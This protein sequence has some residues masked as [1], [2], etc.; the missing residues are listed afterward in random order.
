MKKIYLA[1]MPLIC[2]LFFSCENVMDMHQ[3]YIKG[4]EIIYATRLDTT[5]FVAGNGRV[6]FNYRIFNAPNV[7]SIHVYWND[8]QDSLTIPVTLIPDTVR[9][10]QIISNLEE[11]AYTF[12]A[13]TEDKHGNKSLM[14]NGFSTS[15]GE[16]YRALL[17]NRRVKSLSVDAGGGVINWYSGADGLVRNE[18]RYVDS[19]GMLRTVFMP[20]SEGQVLCPDVQV[21]GSFE[22]RSAYIPE[23]ASIDTFYTAW[24]AADEV[25][26]YQFADVNRS[27]WEVLF[28]DNSDPEE[29]S[30]ANMFDNN[31]DSYWHSNYHSATRF[32]YTFIIDMK[33]AV[34]IGEIGAQS[35]QHNNYSKGIEFYTK[36]TY[37]N[38]PQEGGWTK[39]GDFEL[40]QSNDFY[41]KMCSDNILD[42]GI[43]A[44]YLK[45]VF[46]S[47]HNG[48]HLGAIAELSVRKVVE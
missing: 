21:K 15:Y 31:A 1:F 28:Y 8:F 24:V 48:E 41:W 36:E 23:Q 45:V 37:N 38:D 29:G 17:S 3:E 18:I 13:Q 22:Y 42:L 2:A 16:R 35:R 19:E 10:N 26:P 14:S 25:F 46:T 7:K 11:K 44:R 6:Q 20:A 30:V 43:K 9:G 27:Q 12:Y 34:W 40:P 33:E 47:G 5:Y 32:P 39:L 4:G